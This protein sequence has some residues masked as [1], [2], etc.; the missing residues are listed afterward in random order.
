MRFLTSI[1]ILFLSC[2]QLMAQDNDK[3][4]IT[5][6]DFSALR[7]NL[8]EI[9]GS[10]VNVTVPGTHGEPVQVKLQASNILPERLQKKYPSI[11]AW[12]GHEVGKPSKKVRIEQSKDGWSL[13]WF[14]NQGRFW[15]KSGAERTFTYA[16]HYPKKAFFCR[17]TEMIAP[18]PQAQIRSN[19]L[20]FSQEITLRLALTT[21]YSFTQYHDG[22]KEKT[23]A[24]LVTI[25]NRLNEVYEQELGVHFVLPEKQDTIIVTDPDE[26][27]ISSGSEDVIN[28]RFIDDR[29]GTE[30]YDVGHIL[31]VQS[32]GGYAYLGVVCREGEKARGYT[33][34]PTGEGE[35]LTI[36]YLAHEIGHQFGADHTFNGASGSCEFAIVPPNAV[37]PGSGSSIMAYAGICGSD[38]IQ[39]SSDAFF[40]VRSAQQVRNLLG[41]LEDIGDCGE[42]SQVPHEA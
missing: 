21:S 42:I 1:F 35:F 38:N 5:G 20:N 16:K 40:H 37:E 12:H 11:R 39:S 3:Q 9:K 22:S 23:L 4:I 27:D 19:Q 13:A 36:D 30:N 29:I 26:F 6:S 7:Q 24:A 17:G 8:T 14:T 41:I 32:A 31:D 2:V 34:A 28:Q 33:G 10:S 25:V 18:Q 15:A